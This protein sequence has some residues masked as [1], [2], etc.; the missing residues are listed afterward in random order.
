VTVNVP[1]DAAPGMYEG[2]LAVAG[3]QIPVKLTVAG[4]TLPK[5]ADYETYVDFIESPE[6][7]ALRYDVPLWSDKHFALLGSCF[8]Q[9]GKIGNKTLFLPLAAMAN[10]GNEHTI[11][12]WIKTEKEKISSMISPCSRDTWMSA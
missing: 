8:D 9:L 3:R 1:A 2:T 10:L 7:V 5:P 4:W 11:V 12:R 6:S